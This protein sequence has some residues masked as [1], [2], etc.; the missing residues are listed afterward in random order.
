MQW[1]HK[2]FCVECGK[3][4]Q[5][6]KEGVCTNC[7]IKTHSFSKGPSI[8]DL[9][10]CS[11]CDS[12]KYKNTW[13]SDLFSDV[14]RRVVKN[15]FQ[16]SKELKK[17]GIATECKEKKEG[18]EC[19]VVISGFLG[20]VEITEE[21]ELL[22]R[23]KKTVCDVCSKKYGGY[24]EAVLQIRADKRKPSP[25]ELHNIRLSV[26]SLVEGIQAKGNR[27]LFITDIGE[28]RGGLDFYLSDKGASLVIAKKIKDQYG[29]IIKQ[30]SKNIGMKDSKQVHRM[31]YLLRIPAYRT[32]NFIYHEKSFFYI[33]S[34][35]GNKV[36]VYDLASWDERVLDGKDLQKANIFGGEEIVKE[37]ILVSQTKQEVQ[38]MDPKSYEINIIKKPKPV[39]LTSEKIKIVVIDDK[40]FL[41]PEKFKTDK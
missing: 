16:I 9:P 37:M 17:I 36:H 11:H 41:F 25:D 2:M 26:E 24:H 13:T 38:V 4:G 22:V 30:S 5:I 39:S 10:T 18:M 29:G 35:T 1:C 31:T 19:K 3:E 23:L 6:Y 20:D 34:I 28:E 8:I 12:F 32:G 7:Y 14:I 27:N 33:S 40:M 15:F 21:H